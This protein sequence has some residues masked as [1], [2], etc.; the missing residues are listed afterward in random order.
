MRKNDLITGMLITT[1]EGLQYV[2]I[3]NKLLEE[4]DR[5]VRLSS[6]G[7]RVSRFF[8]NLDEYGDNLTM[9][10]GFSNLDIVKVG[11]AKNVLDRDTQLVPYKEVLWVREQYEEISGAELNTM[12]CGDG[13]YYKDDS[14]G[15]YKEGWFV[16]YCGDIAYLNDSMDCLD[17]AGKVYKRGK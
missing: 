5:V 15:E 7:G 17:Y 14:T 8:I 3:R 10:S 1:R 6:A 11:V 2:V 12:K 4:V 13:L 9:R 16:R